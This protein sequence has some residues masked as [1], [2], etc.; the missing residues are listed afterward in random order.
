MKK[1]SIYFLIFSLI[2]SVSCT[3]DFEEINTDQN[4]PASVRADLLLPGL[5]RSTQTAVYP[6]F[7]DNGATWSQQISQIE[8]VS[9]ERYSPRLATINNTWNILYTQVIADSKSMTTFSQTEG[10]K[11]LEAISLILRANAFQTLTDVYG[12]IPFTEANVKGISKPKYDSQENVYKGI[13]ALLTEADGLI[14][15]TKSNVPAAADLL[16]AGNLS[17]WKK[18]ANSLKLRA[19][20]RIS[21]APGINNAAEIQA[22][23]TAGNLMSSE[24]DSAKIYNLT[25]QAS[26]HPFFATL[27][28]RKEFK[29]SSVLVSKLNTYNDPRLAIYA[30]KNDAGIYVGNVPGADTRNYPGTSAIGSFYKKADLFSILLSYSQVQF[31][32]AEAANEGYIAN[33]IIS[34]TLSQSEQYLKNGIEANFIYN[35]L[36]STEA[37]TYSSQ[38]LFDY[39]TLTEGR[40]IIGEQVW[41]STYCQG[42]EP[43]VEWRRTNIPALA[44]VVQASLNTIPGRYNYPA[45]ESS[46]NQV[47]NALGSALITGGDLLTSKVWW[48]VN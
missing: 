27:G 36:T 1:K 40:K 34:G 31:L 26:A 21:K 20:I 3:K 45:L 13:I 5:I 10:N 22:L 4:S 24:A 14:D 7:G 35:G 25:D 46:V 19:L 9:E 42:F 15:V 16:F 17:K 37:T 8:Y 44:P 39:T 43:W 30:D 11:N 32:L 41:L 47:N 38:N 28:N 6:M 2:I 23:V 33:P 48:D 18:F 12:P 29:V